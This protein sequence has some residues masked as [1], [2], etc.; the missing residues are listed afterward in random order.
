MVAFL[1]GAERRHAQPFDAVESFVQLFA[2][3]KRRGLGAAHACLE[4]AER[5]QNEIELGSRRR[6]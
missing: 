1:G 3:S 5:R 2:H 6:R 4:R